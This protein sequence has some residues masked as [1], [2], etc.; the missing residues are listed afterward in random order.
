MISDLGSV[1]SA[2]LGLF[3]LEFTLYGFTFSFWQ[4][5][6]FTVIASL[7]AWILV[8]VFLGD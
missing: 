4:V 7:I 5:F 2:V 8:E 3:Q 1:L 6:A